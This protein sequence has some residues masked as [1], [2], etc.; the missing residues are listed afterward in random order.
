MMKSYYGLMPT[1]LEPPSPAATAPEDPMGTVP[2][3]FFFAM[4][5]MNATQLSGGTVKIIDSTT[6]PISTTIAAAD[7]TVEP[8][9]IRELHVSLFQRQSH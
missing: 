7:V 1:I 4:S 9:A 8:G 2:E 5:K 6:F 3:G